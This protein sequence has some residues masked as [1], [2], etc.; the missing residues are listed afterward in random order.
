MNPRILHEVRSISSQL[1]FVSCGQGLALVPKTMS[2]LAPENVRLVSLRE[3]MSIVTTAVAWP[4]NTHAP[5]T[6]LAVDVL[7]RVLAA[8]E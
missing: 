7:R 6:D 4:T 5:M 1:A 2:R 3:E 8:Q